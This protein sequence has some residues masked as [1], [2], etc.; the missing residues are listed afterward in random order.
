[1]KRILIFTFLLFAVLSVTTNAHAVIIFQEDFNTV[2]TTIYGV[3]TISGTGADNNW[4]G[5]RFAPG[6]GTIASDIFTSPPNSS[7]GANATNVR[8]KDDAGILI[9]ASTAGYENVTLSFNWRA[10]L[11]LSSERLKVGYFIGD[12]SGFAS[13]RTIDLT[14]G[15]ASWSNWTTLL[16][17]KTAAAPWLY[18]TYSLPGNEDDLWLAF[19]YN[20]GD[21]NSRYP[22]VGN[23]SVNG[24][25][26][27]V[28]TP[29][30]G[31]VVLLGMG[32][33]GLVSR[34]FRRKTA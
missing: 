15:A 24:D 12:I 22:L 17:S 26:I 5:V 16:S 14:T 32:L 27:P 1:M 11:P 8:F 29:E 31:S 28:A 30:P 23:I 34:K 10:Y 2:A 13:D 21:G 7:L 18:S 19:W 9:N 3:P 6:S 33:A 25:L 4:Y 20:S